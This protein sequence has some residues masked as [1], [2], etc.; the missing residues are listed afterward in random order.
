MHNLIELCWRVVLDIKEVVESAA[1]S[2]INAEQILHLCAITCG[3]HYKLSAIV[4]HTLHQLLKSLCTL[5]VSIA[6]GA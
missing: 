2:R 1:E 5:G 3:N 4:L 6:R